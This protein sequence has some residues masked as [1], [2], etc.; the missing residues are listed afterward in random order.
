MI[1]KPP[2]MTETNTEIIDPESNNDRTA[3]DLVPENKIAGV[4]RNWNTDSEWDGHDYAG[5]PIP[6]EDTR[7]KPEWKTEERRAWLLSK[8]R[9]YGTWDNVPMS[10]ADAGEMFGI[11]QNSIYNDIKELR[12]Y[13]RFHAGDKVISM[14]EM[15]AQKAVN[16]LIDEES[17]EYDPYKAWRVQQEYGEWMFELG[18]LD[19]APDKKQVHNINQDVSEDELSDDEQEHF[20]NFSEK[21][22]QV[23]Q[24]P[25]DVESTEMDDDE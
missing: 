2:T 12:R 7:P 22:Q 16:E 5:T 13:I 20:K 24:D 3:D 10:Q 25:I 14:S 17:D 6:R 21:L 4:Q 1:S 23:D 18:R 11:S 9:E 19:R 8:L 15:V